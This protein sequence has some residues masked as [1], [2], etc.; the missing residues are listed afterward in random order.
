MLVAKFQRQL[1]RVLG[2]GLQALNKLWVN[3]ENVG[4]NGRYLYG[5]N[6]GITFV[7]LF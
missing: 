1:N 6:E 3:A 2:T 4:A 5:G 7:T